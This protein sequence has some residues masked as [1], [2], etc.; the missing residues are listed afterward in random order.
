MVAR[1]IIGFDRKIA[2]SWLDATADWAA[3][4][5]APAAIRQRLGRLLDGQVAG[6]GLT[7]RGKTMTVLLRVCGGARLQSRCWRATMTLMASPL[8]SMPT[9]EPVA[10]PLREEPAGVYRIGDT[11]VLLE[12]VVD[13]FRSGATP[14]TI[15]QSYDT[16]RLADV[17]AVLAYCLPI[18]NRS[19]TTCGAMMP[20]PQ[21]CA[22]GS[23]R[24]IG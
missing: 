2:L 6:A 9:I 11:R 4:G 10:V 15:V 14:E 1:R 21:T 8:P 7:A 18:K 19:T 24:R 3:Q 17:Y 16:L 13:A 20:R 22:A 23:R 5:L 12:V